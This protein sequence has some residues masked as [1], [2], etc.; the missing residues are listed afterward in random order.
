MEE[1]HKLRGQISNIVQTNFPGVNVGFVSNLL[2]PTALQVSWNAKR[3]FLLPNLHLSSKFSDNFWLRGLLT[4]SL[5][6]KILLRVNP[7]ENNLQHR[8][9]YHTG[10]SASKRTSIYIR[11]LSSPTHHHQSMLCSTKSFEPHAYGWKVCSVIIF[12]ISA[13][14]VSEGLTVVNPTWLSTLG[15]PSLC[16]FAKPTKNMA[17]VMM[18]IPRFGPDGWELPAIKAETLHLI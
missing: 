4:K 17:G 16:T 6:A 10:P 9:E 13:E 14:K 2:P 7:P 1:I 11:L 12:L 8:K 18:T 15:R 3:V 5:C